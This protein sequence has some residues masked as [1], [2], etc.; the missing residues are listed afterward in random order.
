M[1]SRR[2]NGGDLENYTKPALDVLA[3]HGDDTMAL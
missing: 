1:H 3:T 2:I